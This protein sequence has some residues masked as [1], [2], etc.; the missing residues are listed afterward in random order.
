MAKA[1]A[2]FNLVAFRDAGMN[3]AL[4]EGE[5]VLRGLESRWLS[6]LDYAVW[7]MSN[8]ARKHMTFRTWNYAYSIVGILFYNGK[9]VGQETDGAHFETRTK[10]STRTKNY[11]WYKRVKNNPIYAFD[12]HGG[13]TPDWKFATKHGLP[14]KG[15]DWALL[16]TEAAKKEMRNTKGYRIVLTVGMPY[17]YFNRGRMAERTRA[18]LEEV[19]KSYL[20]REGSVT[21]SVRIDF[22]KTGYNIEEQ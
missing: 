5:R 6:K 17:A 18:T 3:A 16:V 19:V 2:T 4:S 15:S 21:A 9:I 10:S 7:M 12:H 13:T 14:T 20:G 1:K 8:V 11:Y 22:I